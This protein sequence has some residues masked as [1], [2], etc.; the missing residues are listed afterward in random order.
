MSKAIANAIAANGWDSRT[1]AGQTIATKGTHTLTISGRFARWDNSAT[2]SRF[3]NEP[4]E[5]VRAIVAVL[6]DPTI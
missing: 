3:D 4:V 2:Y 5:G 6:S 1:W